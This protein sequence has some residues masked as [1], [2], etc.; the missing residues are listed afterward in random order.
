MS[1]LRTMV[2]LKEETIQHQAMSIRALPEVLAAAE[3]RLRELQARP[4]PFV[5]QS[6][7]G[8]AYC[9]LAEG[10]RTPTPDSGRGR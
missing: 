9:L 6:D 7:E 10:E 1:D 8:T 3:P 5:P 2:R 4:C